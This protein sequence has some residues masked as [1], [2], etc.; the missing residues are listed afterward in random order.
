MNKRDA[1][2]TRRHPIPTR[3]ITLHVTDLMP[4]LIVLLSQ[5]AMF[6]IT[7]PTKEVYVAGRFRD[8]GNFGISHFHAT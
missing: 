3:C 6:D 5:A 8:H 7:E 2:W 1:M 4:L